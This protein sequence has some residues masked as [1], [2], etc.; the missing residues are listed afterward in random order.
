MR[1]IKVNLSQYNICNGYSFVRHRREFWNREKVEGELSGKM[2]TGITKE[3]FLY[4]LHLL[5]YYKVEPTHDH[6]YAT[7]KSKNYPYDFSSVR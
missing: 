1:C 4:W 3:E 5:Q 7:T 2:H 6:R